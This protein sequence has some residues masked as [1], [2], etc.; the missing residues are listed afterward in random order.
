M[1]RHALTDRQGFCITCI[2][3]L[4]ITLLAQAGLGQTLP[5]VAAQ[6]TVVIFTYHESGSDS[7]PSNVFNGILVSPGFIATSAWAMGEGHRN[8]FQSSTDAKPRVRARAVLRQDD[9]VLIVNCTPVPP[10]RSE[11]PL[12]LLEIDATHR[13]AVE[14]MLGPN[15]EKAPFDATETLQ[16]VGVVAPLGLTP[17]DLSP[18]T[19]PAPVAMSVKTGEAITI[20]GGKIPAAELLQGVPAQMVGAGLWD[21]QGR[22]RSLL[23][24]DAHRWIALDLDAAGKLLRPDTPAPP[25]V[26]TA[27]AN[28]DPDKPA[29]PTPAPAIKPEPKPPTPT[30]APA[31]EIKPAHVVMDPKMAAVF[32]QEGLK[33]VMHPI[34]LMHAGQEQ[35]DLIM[36]LI[37]ANQIAEARQMLDDIEPLASGHLGELLS[38]RRAL[39]LILD[40]KYE[41]AARKAKVCLIAKDPNVKASGQVLA[42]VLADHPDGRYEGKV[43]SNN[44]ALA[45]AIVAHLDRE[46]EAMWKRVKAL[47]SEAAG[48]QAA[49]EI[50]ALK[51]RVDGYRLVS[52]AH[53]TDLAEA[54]H[55]SGRSIR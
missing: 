51:R 42:Q 48:D 41:E 21:E 29:P 16:L 25:K 53:F 49:G 28:P 45:D 37:G 6:R 47:S 35:A 15:M 9:K 32:D 14:K 20:V 5:A 17:N 2:A 7:L 43:L 3:G 23:V 22:I 34:L 27:P 4:W 54:L 8:P 1:K 10:A 13:P 12:F 38:Q 36:A 19:L 11:S 31:P 26:A 50:A 30:P 24:R 39:T 44:R 33:P 18:Q 55:G 46:R 40:G 52:P